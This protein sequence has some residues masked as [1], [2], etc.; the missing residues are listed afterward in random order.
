MGLIVTSSRAVRPRVVHVTT[1][2]RAD[3]VRIFEREGRSL[4]RCG[5]YE[6]VL[7]AAGTIP[8]QSGVTL[9]PLVPAPSSRA[10]R[11]TSGP[12]KAFG[13]S[14]AMTADL[15]HF[16]DPELLPVALYLARSG[17]AVIW[18]AHEDYVAQFTENGGKSWVPGPVRGLV[19]R[20]M[21][22]M[23]AAIDRHAT[24]VVAAT[25]TIA[26]RYTNIRTVVVGNEAR[27]EDFLACE[28]DFASHRLLFTGS[29]GPGHLFGE[30]VAAVER[31]PS[32]QLV[33]A[34]RPPQP[35]IWSAAAARL[36]SRLEHVG[37]LDRQGLSREMSRSALGLAT[38]A[39]TDAYAVA[40]PTKLFEFC[41]GGLP[42]L[43]SPTVS[44][45]RYVEEGGGGFL[46]DGFSVDAI[47]R[48]VESALSDREAWE[49]ASA[50]G[51]EWAEREGSWEPS[52]KRLLDLY[53]EILGV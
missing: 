44:N 20:G 28:P 51:R 50:R 13:L 22:A 19:R 6:V 43:A 32:A 36:G 9:L 34:G 42:V 49:L 39:D 41:A 35:S 11:F 48:T 40:A 25:P 14:R 3:D 46:A 21:Q 24:A 27:L 1:A 29:V 2:H 53:Q 26:D 37:W 45:R 15:W 38:Y 7:A 30:V 31:L 12:R 4:A 10:G 33:V 23:L 17:A 16:H 18:D 8:A 5:R 52:E 47:A